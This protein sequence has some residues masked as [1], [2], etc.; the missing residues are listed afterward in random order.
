LPAYKPVVEGEMIATVKIIPFAV[1]GTSRDRAVAAAA[2]DKAVIRVAPYKLRKIGI[3]STLLPGLSP[4]VIE[5]TLKITAARIAPAGA[6]VIAERR[7]GDAHAAPS[8][9]IYEVVQAGAPA[10]DLACRLCAASPP[11]RN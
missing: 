1:A 10:A 4:K 6:S 9:A 5:K 2:K 7:V 11:R 3:I 8:L